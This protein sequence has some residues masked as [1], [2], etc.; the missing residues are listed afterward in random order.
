MKLNQVVNLAEMVELLLD[1]VC[2]VDKSGH[3]VFVSSAFEDIFGYTPDEVIDQPV[4]SYI[5][6]EDKEK[7]ASVVGKILSGDD[8]RSFEN[9]WR[10]KSGRIVNVLWSARWSE[11]HQ[12]RIAVAHDITKRKEMESKLQFLASH[13]T[14][15][16]LPN[17]GYLEEKLKKSFA[18]TQRAKRNFCLLFIDIDKFKLV[19]DSHGHLAGDEVLKIIAKRLKQS[20]RASDV[21]GRLS[22]DEFIVIVNEI[23]GKEDA[24]SLATKICN[25]VEQEMSIDGLRLQLTV[26]IG[27]AFCPND[28]TNEKELL[29][30]ADTAMYEAKRA[31][32]NRVRSIL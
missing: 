6:N 17:R 7:T 30:R 18:Q 22:G 23:D 12:V 1:A 2:V 8:Q 3:I 16:E 29:K 21:V 14:L 26:S 24:Q 13:D 28:V 11:E 20:V 4:A 5:V 32:G 31:G 10:H 27:I 19:N 15:T 9:R 25:V